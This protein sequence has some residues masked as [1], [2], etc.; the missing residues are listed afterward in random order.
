M[1]S[2]D[3]KPNIVFDSAKYLMGEFQGGEMVED[4]FVLYRAEI[5]FLMFFDLDKSRYVICERFNKIEKYYIL[6]KN[7]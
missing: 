7:M 5:T 6:S 4:V 2:P 1:N 3:K